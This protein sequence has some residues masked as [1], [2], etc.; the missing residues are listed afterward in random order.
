MTKHKISHSTEASRG[1]QNLKLGDVKR[2][3]AIA[4]G[5]IRALRRMIEEE[6]YCI[7]I[8][9]QAEAL[10]KALS[11]VEELVLENHVTTH[12]VE[13]VR[14]GKAAKVAKELSNFYKLIR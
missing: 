12:V 9:T 14:G 10:K 11:G 7:D 3:M 2:R 8:L 4:E 1:K 5:Q 13:Q 6:K